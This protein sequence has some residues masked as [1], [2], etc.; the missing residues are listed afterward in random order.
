MQL[1]KSLVA[2]LFLASSVAAGPIA[3]AICQAGC[4]SLAVAC[5]SAAGFTFGTVAA[6][7]A[8]AAL[9]ACNSAY[10]T[11]QPACVVAALVP[12]LGKRS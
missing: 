11:C 2:T 7:A 6:A 12:T 3:Y 9:L 1:L 5:Y 8:P 4:S 10:G